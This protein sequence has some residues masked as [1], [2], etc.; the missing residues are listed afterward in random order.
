MRFDLKKIAAILFISFLVLFLSALLLDSE[1]S[2]TLYIAS[3][4]YIL[5][6]IKGRPLLGFIL[7]ALSFIILFSS[8]DVVFLFFLV[9]I[10]FSI[11]SFLPAKAKKGVPP[12]DSVSNPYLNPYSSGSSGPGGS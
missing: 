3:L 2:A 8:F 11:A 4:F 6:S 9:I 12:A 7:L 1:K 10:I 5:I